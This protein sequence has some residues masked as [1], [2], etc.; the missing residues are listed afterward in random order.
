M[1]ADREDLLEVV[2]GPGDDMD[3]DQFA[4]TP[5]GGRAGVSRG[6]H[7]ADIA[8]YD[9]R[10]QAGVDFL[11]ANED[12]VRGLD[13]RVGGLDHADQTARLDHAQRVADLAPLFF[14]LGFVRHCYW[15]L[16]RAATGMLSIT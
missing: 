7:R 11:P 9:C 12:D 5:G 2:C 6:L 13:H 15:I 10:D 14:F 3:A 1:S 8:A 4:D 16:P